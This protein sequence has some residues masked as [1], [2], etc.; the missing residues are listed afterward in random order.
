MA[1][2]TAGNAKTIIAAKTSIAH[3]NIGMRPSVMPGA[4]V[5]STPIRISIAPAIAEISM[6]PMPSSQKSWFTRGD[7]RAS[8]S[9]GY[10][11]QPPSGAQPT[12]RLRKKPRPPTRYSQNAKADRRGNGRSRAP[13]MF[14]SSAT[15]IASTAGTANR[16][17]ITVP[18][19]VN[20]W[21]YRSGPISVFSGTASC[22][23]IA[24]ASTPASTKNSIAAPR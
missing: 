16:N 22:T 15:P 20:S 10:M 24:S 14:G 23:R 11:N 21:L 19:I 6:K 12:N 17:I 4:R 7:Q 2:I 9:G 18:C 3:A 13:S 1:R 8:V 5:R